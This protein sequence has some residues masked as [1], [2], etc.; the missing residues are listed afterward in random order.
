MWLHTSPKAGHL[1]LVIPWSPLSEC[2]H[3]L[4]NI[5]SLS[6]NSECLSLAR[7]LVLAEVAEGVVDVLR[8][9]GVGEVEHLGH[10]AG[11]DEQVRVVGDVGHV[12]TTIGID[13]VRPNLT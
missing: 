5:L 11:L 13:P 2:K 9:V 10:Q 3:S 6:S 4:Q 12:H 8:I 7:R 1:A